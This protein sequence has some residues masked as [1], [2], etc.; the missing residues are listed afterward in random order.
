VLNV[1]RTTASGLECDILYVLTPAV[2]ST[3]HFSEYYIAPYLS[4]TYGTR[5]FPNRKLKIL[6]NLLVSIVSHEEAG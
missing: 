4:N 5:D 2:R 1:R 6:L 3:T